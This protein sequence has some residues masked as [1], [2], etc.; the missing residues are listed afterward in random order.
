MGGRICRLVLFERV[1]YNKSSQV[2]MERRANTRT[3]R[4]DQVFVF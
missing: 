1:E 4:E 2:V 3:F